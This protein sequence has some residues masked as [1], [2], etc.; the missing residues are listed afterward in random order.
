[1]DRTNLCQMGKNI[2]LK[3]TAV[4]YTLPLSSWVYPNPSLFQGSS[5]SLWKRH[6]EWNGLYVSRTDSNAYVDLFYEKGRTLEVRG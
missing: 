4:E 5:V 2:T 6:R 1:M 3:Q